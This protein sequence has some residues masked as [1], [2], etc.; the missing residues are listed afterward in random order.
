[1]GE[2]RGHIGGALLTITGAALI[3]ANPGSAVLFVI[4]VLCFVLALWVLGVWRV[5]WGWL[6]RRSASQPLAAPSPSVTTA[7]QKPPP[8]PAERLAALYRDSEHLQT[9]LLIERTAVRAGETNVRRQIELEQTVRAWDFQVEVLLPPGARSRWAQLAA[10]PA[11]HSMRSLI[12]PSISIDG[13]IGFVE[14]KRG[15][16]REIIERMGDR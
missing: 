5:L 15:R 14:A 2:H 3:A 9:S 1:M 10:L 16:L 8:T 7:I 12:E 13:L 6:P 4:A 11:F